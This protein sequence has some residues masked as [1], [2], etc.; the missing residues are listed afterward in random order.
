MKADIGVIGMA[1]MGQNLA[2]NMESKGF[3]V[4]V[5]NRTTEKTKEFFEERCKGKKVV[6]GYTLE[7]FLGSLKKP[8]R[9]MIMVKAGKPVDDMIALVAPHLEKGDILIDGGNSFFQD[10]RRRAAGAEAK[11]L[12]YI[13]TGV[14]GGE[15]GALHGPS[16][17][18]GD[19]RGVPG[20]GT[21]SYGDLGQG[22]GRSLLHLHRAGR[23]R[24]L[25]QDGPQ[26]DRVRRHAVDQ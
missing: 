8:R 6:P 18:P 22:G 2:L 4:A 20:R 5:F 10:T 17:M 24:A 3:T 9:I 11:G 7:E 12:L 15:E 1:V 25:R 14:S 23:R 16:I 19:S 26:R 13:G 21:H